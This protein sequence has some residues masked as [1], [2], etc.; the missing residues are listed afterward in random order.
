MLSKLKSSSGKAK[1][2]GPCDFKLAYISLWWHRMER[3]GWKDSQENPMRER[4]TIYLKAGWTTQIETKRRVNHQDVQVETKSKS[5]H[6]AF[7]ETSLRNKVDSRTPPLHGTCTT[8]LSEVIKEHPSTSTR[9]V[10]S[11]IKYFENLTVKQSLGKKRHFQGKSESPAK[12]AR[13]NN[14]HT[15]GPSIN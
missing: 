6:N 4:M 7:D 10:A 15:R 3:E 12:L 14:L 13:K 1:K 11:K 8:T 2:P 9:P 5:G